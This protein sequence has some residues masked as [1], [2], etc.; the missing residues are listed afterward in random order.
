MR[1]TEKQSRRTE[2]GI[3]EGFIEKITGF[4]LKINNCKWTNK[5]SKIVKKRS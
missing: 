1:E 3:R 5:I 4:A 2:L